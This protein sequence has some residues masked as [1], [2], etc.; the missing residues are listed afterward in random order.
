M[1]F[2]TSLY[3]RLPK[4]A[5]NKLLRAS[6]VIYQ[7]NNHGSGIGVSLSAFW[8]GEAPALGE[9]PAGYIV[10]AQDC[11]DS[12]VFYFDDLQEALTCASS[13]FESKQAEFEEQRRNEGANFNFLPPDVSV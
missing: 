5:A 8:D 6:Y 12:E 2:D 9:R 1:T 3:T 10:K 13:Y 11:E 7:R 4:P